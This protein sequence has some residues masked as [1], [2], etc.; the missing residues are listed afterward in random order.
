MRSLSIAL[1]VIAALAGCATSAGNMRQDPEAK[2]SVLLP[3]NYQLVLKRINERFAECTPA[4]MLPLGTMIN[5]VQHYSDLRQAS[6]TRGAEGVGRQ[7][8]EVID[9]RETAPG[10]TEL[11]VFSK[12]RK[13]EKLA[14]MRRWAEGDLACY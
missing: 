6:I 4:P 7:I 2:R 9:I 8:H 14:T 13:D 5:D 1:T 12:V 10:Q 11:S 3:I